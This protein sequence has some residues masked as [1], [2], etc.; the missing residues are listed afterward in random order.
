MQ[1]AEKKFVK[2][3]GTIGRSPGHGIVLLAMGEISMDALRWSD[4]GYFVENY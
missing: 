4:L 2:V 3:D 1:I